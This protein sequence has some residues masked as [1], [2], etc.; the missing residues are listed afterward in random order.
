MELDKSQE[1]HREV[2]TKYRGCK[3]Y[4]EHEKKTKES[5]LVGDMGQKPERKMATTM[6]TKAHDWCDNDATPQPD[7]DVLGH[8]NPVCRYEPSK[9]DLA[10]YVKNPEDVAIV[11]PSN[12]ESEREDVMPE[13]FEYNDP[14][15]RSVLTWRNYARYHNYSFYSGLPRNHEKD[16]PGL[17]ARHPAWTKPCLSM[18]LIKKHK[19]L[20]VVDR[21]TTVIKPRL[22]LEPL[23]EL[24]G[25]LNEKS[26]KFMAVS[27][28]WGS[29][30]R[31]VRSP[32]SGDVNTGIMLI[33]SSPG[34]AA[35][36]TADRSCPTA[37]YEGRVSS[38]KHEPNDRT[39]AC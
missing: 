6:F 10:K 38:T 20:I 30:I 39:L 17:E 7:H 34:S 26:G 1:Q 31:G 29:C 15:S 13:N 19:F 21:D 18:Q 32:S 33:R 9:E 28:E 2:A 24:A 4:M 12:Q 25:L 22:R 27:E 8:G 3:K 14:L 36:R 11:V 16:C 37:A 23:F 5:L 35:A